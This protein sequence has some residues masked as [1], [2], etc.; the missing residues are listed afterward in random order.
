MNIGIELSSARYIAMLDQDD[1]MSPNRLK[2]SVSASAKYPDASFVFGDFHEFSSH[3]VHI[4]QSDPASRS[5][6][7]STI[8]FEGEPA[9]S[10]LEGATWRSIFFRDPGIQNSC[11]NHFFLKSVW[12]MNGGY[13]ESAFLASDYDFVIRSFGKGVVWLKEHVFKKRVHDNNAWTLQDHSAVQMLLLQRE[14]VSNFEL[15]KHRRVYREL[16]LRNSNRY[17]WI[18]KHELAM[19]YG[20]ELIRSGYLFTGAVELTKTF[21]SQVRSNALMKPETRTD[22]RF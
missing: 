21:L 10:F 20:F 11:S 16:I 18:G 22:D 14:L 15:E 13:R 17:R 19:Q 5:L 1:L 9:A 12:K 3:C 7:I 4:P 8:C 2:H 6:E